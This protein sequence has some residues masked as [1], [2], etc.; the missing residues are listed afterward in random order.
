[1][2]MTESIINLAAALAKFQGMVKNPPK[3]KEAKVPLKNGG[4]YSYKYADLGVILDTIREPLAKC[5]LSFFQA[6]VNNERGELEGVQTILMHESGEHIV[7]EPVLIKAGSGATAQ[8]VGSALTYARRYSLCL[9]LGIVAD[10]DDD[11]NSASEPPKTQRQATTKKQGN[12]DL[13]AFEELA[14]QN[15]KKGSPDK[16]Y[17]AI[18]NKKGFQKEDLNVLIWGAY[19]MDSH[20]QLDDNKFSILADYLDKVEPEKFSLTVDCFRRIQKWGLEKEQQ[21]AVFFYIGGGK[22]DWRAFSNGELKEAIEFL[23][24]ASQE[25]MHRTVEAMREAMEQGAA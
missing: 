12:G 16:R 3:T 7:F 19:R 18:A 9:A 23:E 8:Q 5:G 6:P 20:K 15:K 14:N 13:S 22:V 11:G 21:K 17:W 2:K 1:V 4:S 10:E 25:E 24:T